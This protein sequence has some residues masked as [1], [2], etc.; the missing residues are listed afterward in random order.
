VK[1]VT[2]TSVKWRWLADA[3]ADLVVVRCSIGRHGEAHYLQRADEDLLALAVD[4]VA[5]ATGAREPPIDARVVRWGGCMPQYQVGHRDRVARVRR[6]VAAA[7]GLAVCGA[8]YDGVG[9][10]GCVASGQQAAAQVEQEL[11]RAGEW[12]HG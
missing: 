12:A 1:A 9:V 11:A 2:F 5:A 7:G 4:D 6:A 10:A 8:A 3:A